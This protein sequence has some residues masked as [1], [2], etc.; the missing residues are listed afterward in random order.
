MCHGS[1]RDCNGIAPC[2]HP[3]PLCS[4]LWQLV[5]VV[6]PALLHQAHNVKGDAYRQPA[7][8]SALTILS[9]APSPIALAVVLG[10]A[11]VGELKFENTRVA[12]LRCLATLVVS[13]PDKLEP[14]MVD[15]VVG[16]VVEALTDEKAPVRAEAQETFACLREHSEGAAGDV[17]ESLRAKLPAKKYQ[18]LEK[19][20][21]L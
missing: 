3:H 5:G 1:T 11:G 15:G 2:S 13:L 18:A 8:E 7:R 10:E 19:R 12:A 14:P 16:A 17:L 4:L 9:L 21:L 6:L 20:L